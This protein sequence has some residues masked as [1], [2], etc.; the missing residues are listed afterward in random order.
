M[1]LVFCFVVLAFDSMDDVAQ[2]IPQPKTPPDAL[3]RAPS[4]HDEEEP[5]IGVQPQKTKLLKQ[6]PKP[7]TSPNTFQ[8]KSKRIPPKGKTSF[9]PR[10]LRNLELHQERGVRKPGLCLCLKI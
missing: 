3:M 9:M 10:R 7:T 8:I 2:V 1:T 6:T 4:V 5:E